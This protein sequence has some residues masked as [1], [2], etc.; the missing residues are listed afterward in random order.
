MNG[1]GAAI[2]DFLEEEEGLL[3]RLHKRRAKNRQ[4]NKR[5]AFYS[6]S[7]ALL[8]GF[9]VGSVR[10]S[11]CSNDIEASTLSLS[12][13]TLSTSLYP[14][15]SSR[16]VASLQQRVSYCQ[17]REVEP[18]LFQHHAR[19]GIGDAYRGFIVAFLLAL[20][21]CVPFYTTWRQDDTWVI[22]PR[23]Q[24]PKNIST[25]KY[26][27]C[28]KRKW[29]LGKRAVKLQTNCPK[30][31]K[32]MMKDVDF[33]KSLEKA[34]INVFQYEEESWTGNDA[35]V[36]FGELYNFV[37]KPH[38]D[39]LEEVETHQRVIE[40]F[41]ETKKLEHVI[42]VHFRSGDQGHR[43]GEGVMDQLL[44]C[45][46]KM[47]KNLWGKTGIS[48]IYFLSDSASLKEDF[49]EKNDRV[50]TSEIKPKHSGKRGGGAMSAW[51]DLMLLSRVDAVIRTSG[52]F[53]RVAI[54]I[55]SMRSDHYMT[56]E[57][58]T[59]GRYKWERV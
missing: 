35:M 28:P 14:K 53:S 32:Q 34:G 25:K 20:D 5:F 51:I 37:Y 43:G 38:F 24:P 54:S 6:I 2:D 17:S 4:R 15:I 7:C 18:L 58:G 19:L 56:C 31:R 47:E 45:V 59:G 1:P 40:E 13:T 9:I 57:A 52:G 48:V 46:E 10:F 33:W 11:P 36:Q 30:F 3:N 55:A 21:R 29:E 23:F 39:L 41:M 50:F 12:S 44:E 16:A 26:S 49:K 22:D 8:L 27:S 42:G